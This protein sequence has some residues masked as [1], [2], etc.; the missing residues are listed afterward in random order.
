MKNVKILFFILL[1][2][3]VSCKKVTLKKE[4]DVTNGD[5]I[6]V[7]KIVANNTKEISVGSYEKYE[8]LPKL[9]F[10]KISKK[11]FLSITPQNNIE[12]FLPKYEGD[13]F[14]VQTKSKIHK[15]Q[16][17]RNY[18]NEKGW[19]GCEPLVYYPELKMFAIV[20]NFTSES[21]GFGRLFLLDSLTDCRYI[22]ESFGDGSVAL[23]NPSPNN[24][25]LVY[26]YN[27]P[28]EHARCEIGILAIKSKAN[29]SKY[30]T[31]YRSCS[32]TDFKI[33]RLVW[34]SDNSFYIEAYKEVLENDTW[35]EKY[36]Y[37]KTNF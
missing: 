27:Y 34:E 12:A 8:K 9:T 5:S 11:E 14:F 22:I 3:V 6:V 32:S 28:Y 26:F 1:V 19:N 33:K 15:F 31:E 25:Y 37:Y 18:G 16:K 35:I 13:F 24:K 36:E 17:Y 20:E 4:K 2:T 29:P 10:E 21:I 30:L 7:K 23:P